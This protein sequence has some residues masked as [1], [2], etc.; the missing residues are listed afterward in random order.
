MSETAM[1]VEMFPIAQLK[2]A[3]EEICNG[4]RRRLCE[5]WK[6]SFNE[7]WWHGDKIGGGLFIADWW[8]PLEMQELRYVVENGVTQ[9]A[10]IE[11][12][13][14]VESEIHNGQ[15][16]PRINFH[17]WFVLGARPKDLKDGINTQSEES[18]KIKEK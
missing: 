3:Y 12:C 16:C 14:F 17:S 13:D 10:W 2:G 4:Y 11:Y 8:C 9:G 5:M 7:T 6:L 18:V 15:K 1:S